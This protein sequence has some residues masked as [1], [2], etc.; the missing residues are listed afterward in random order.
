VRGPWGNATNAISKGLEEKGYRPIGQPQG[1]IVKGKYGPLRDGEVERA[2]E[3]G[4]ELA[5]LMG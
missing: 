1:F 4:A 3:W 2:R 5:R